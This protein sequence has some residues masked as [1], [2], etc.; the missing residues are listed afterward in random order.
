MVKAN[1]WISAPILKK[2]VLAPNH[3]AKFAIQYGCI[4]QV[5]WSQDR[6]LYLAY[7]EERRVAQW[8]LLL[9]ESDSVE[10]LVSFW[11]FLFF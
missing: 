9:L 6:L 5:K 10:D 11:F 1:D 3:S 7:G 2:C 4:T 8:E